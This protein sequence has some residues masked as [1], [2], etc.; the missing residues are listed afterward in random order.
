MTDATKNRVKSILKI[1]LKFGVSGLVIWYVFSKIDIRETWQTICNANGWLVAAAIVVYSL[2]QIV[3]AIRLNILFRTIPFYISTLANIKLYWLG[4]FYNISLPGGVGGDGYKIYYLHKHHGQRVKALSALVLADRLNGL[5]IIVIFLLLFASFFVETLPFPYHK[6]YFLAVPLVLFGY[7]L[8]VRIFKHCAL[9]A[10]W[11]VS[12]A[13]V[14][15]Q[16]LQMCSVMLILIS[17]V[18]TDC[19]FENYI[20]L[21]FISSIASAIPITMGGAGAREATFLIGS[22]YLSTDPSVAIALSLMFYANSLICA[23]PGIIY[24]LRPSLIEKSSKL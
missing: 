8:F 10:F 2:S 21:F 15:S 18:G 6:F 7:W 17:L 1:I 9:R 23:V 11:Q 19:S 13:S 14:I 4:L 5:C 12:L 16:G 20:F 3:A 24:A 22:Q